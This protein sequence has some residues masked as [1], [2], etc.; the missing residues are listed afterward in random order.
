MQVVVL[1]TTIAGGI[2]FLMFNPDSPV[3]HF[4]M[5]LMPLGWVGLFG[6]RFLAERKK[7]KVEKQEEGNFTDKRKD[8]RDPAELIEKENLKRG[9]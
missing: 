5:A 6:L 3:A 1:I 8:F 9:N 7:K 4:L 2:Y